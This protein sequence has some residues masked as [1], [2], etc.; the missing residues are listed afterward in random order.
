MHGGTAENLTVKAGGVADIFK[1]KLTGKTSLAKKAMLN[2]YGTGIKAANISYKSTSKI[3]YSLNYLDPGK[4]AL[5]TRSSGTQK[6]NATFSV[7]IYSDWQKTGTYKLSSR[8]KIAANKAF[9]IRTGSIM[10]G[11]DTKVATVKL[12][13]APVI[14]NGLSY[15]IT[16]RKNVVSLKLAVAPGKMLIGKATAE[17]LTGTTDSDIFY[18]GKGND[19]I[20]GKN[21]RDVAVYDKNNWG[22]DTIYKTSGNMT[23]V[24]AGVKESAVK[25]KYNEKSGTM[26]IWKKKAASQKITVK[27]WGT[28]THRI[29]YGAKLTAFN[30]YLKAAAPT[31]KQKTAAQNELY[32][33]ADASLATST[34]AG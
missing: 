9:T 3:N 27:G 30:K 14:K 15:A 10:E 17:K 13:A 2:I 25:T 26:T 21:G 6:L 19:K 32:K 5:L 28:D 23:L 18:G 20:Y 31:E 22:K 7:F 16:S 8:F 34:T 33:I 11:G 24:L 12:G 1:G 4:A 29:V